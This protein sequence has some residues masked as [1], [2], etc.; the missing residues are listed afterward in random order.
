MV[1]DGNA[2][3]NVSTIQMNTSDSTATAKLTEI[4][5][6]LLGI[7]PIGIDQNYFDLGGDS[8]L[9]VHLFVRI[10]KV[11]NVKL[12]LATLFEA[13][14]IEELARVL[15]DQTSAPGW[16]TLVPIQPNGS[17]PPF[18]CMHPHGGNVLVYRGLAKQMGDDQPFFGLQS[19]GLDG[20]QPPLSKIEDMAAVY[21]KEIR[22]AQPR[23][24]YFLGGYCM[25][26]ILAYEVACQLRQVGEEVAL[27]ALFDTME[28]SSLPTLSLW[29]RAYYNSERLLFHMT[30]L[31]HLNSADRVRF[32]SEKLQGVRIRL[33]VWLTK[34]WGKPAR[35]PG[36]HSVAPESEI[37]GK[38]WE[39]NF[40]A[41]LNYVPRPYR[42]TVT[43][44]RPFQQ[45]RVYDQPQLKWDRLADVQNT[46]V[47]PVNPTAILSEPFVNHLAVVLTK[48]L[49]ESTHAAKS[50]QPHPRE[51]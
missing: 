25:G 33:E 48:C 36:K 18:F 13:P 12:P 27:L 23:G 35:Q 40:R 11:F 31:L 20:T 47:L 3:S 8:S 45:Y 14:T 19:Q 15:G 21:V 30:N 4:W 22:K 7:D 38:V 49:V 17:R 2:M 16:S 9:A 39:G 1:P 28:L 24:P 29:Q 41:C 46:I 50:S 42:G 5:Q 10:E 34:L 32:V 43:D 44:I 51:L 6:E 37:L 26:G